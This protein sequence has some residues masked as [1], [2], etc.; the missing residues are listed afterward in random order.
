MLHFITF[1]KLVPAVSRH[2]FICSRISSVWRSIATGRISPVCGSNGDD[3]AQSARRRAGEL[4]PGIG[5]GVSKKS[6]GLARIQPGTG[7]GT[8]LREVP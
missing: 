8:V 6:D 3:G 5:T 2:S 1:S 7:F 4:R